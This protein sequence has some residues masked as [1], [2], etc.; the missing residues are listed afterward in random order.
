MPCA[1]GATDTFLSLSHHVLKLLLGSC[2]VLWSIVAAGSLLEII[3]HGVYKV[4]I[5]NP[6][7]KCFVI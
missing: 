4:A 5:F 7:T 3:M 1:P 2:T 6:V